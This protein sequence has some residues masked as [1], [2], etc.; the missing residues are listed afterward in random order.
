MTHVRLSPKDTGVK[1]LWREWNASARCAWA[2]RLLHKGTWPVAKKVS[3]AEILPTLHAEPHTKV[4]PGTL[5]GY[6]GQIRRSSEAQHAWN[7][8]QDPRSVVILLVMMDWGTHLVLI[9]QR[10]TLWET[11]KIAWITNY[12]LC[13]C[14]PLR[15]FFPLPD[16]PS[17]EHKNQV[18]LRR[19][20][21][22]AGESCGCM[23]LIPPFYFFRRAFPGEG[24]FGS[25]ICT[26]LSVPHVRKTWHRM[27][28]RRMEGKRLG[29]I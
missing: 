1:C 22:C 25:G 9:S 27:Y 6:K 20:K 28:L 12:Y 13:V 15:G 18:N 14:F 24:G 29:T 16:K 8:F 21:Y 3:G 26:E 19:I 5:W 23:E 11:W 2:V 17:E 10:Y 4:S 7:D